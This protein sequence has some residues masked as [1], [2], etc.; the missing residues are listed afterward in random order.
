MCFISLF[1]PLNKV[2]NM[3]NY[4]NK[5]YYSVFHQ[6]KGAKFAYGGSILS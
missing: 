5:K 4:L 6:F 1:P 3:P 2:S